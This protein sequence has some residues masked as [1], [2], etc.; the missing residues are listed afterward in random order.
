MNKKTTL[1][2]IG[3]ILIVITALVFISSNEAEPINKSLNKCGDGICDAKEKANLELCPEDC[4]L[5]DNRTETCG[6]DNNGYCIDFREECKTGYEDIGPDTCRRGRSAGCCVSVES[7]AKKTCAEQNG[8]ICSSSQ[9]CSGSWLDASDSERCCDGVCE[10]SEVN[11]ADSP[12]GISIAGFL[13][14]QDYKKSLQYMN[15]A[16]A[17]TVR[18]MSKWGGLNWE[19]IEPQKGVF[20]W[21]KTD[22]H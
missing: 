10:N 21:S 4:K 5:T 3:I 20:D 8:T 17:D 22:E 15:E 13:S 18:F 2:I 6:Q 19:R 1:I 9:T 12:F 14:N 11:Y 16:G 7:L